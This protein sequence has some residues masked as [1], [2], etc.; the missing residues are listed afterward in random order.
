MKTR[1]REPRVRRHLV[2][3]AVVSACLLTGCSEGPVE[4]DDPSGSGVASIPDPSVTSKTSGKSAADVDDQ[5]PL[6]RLDA[7]PADKAALFNG[8]VKCLVA[9]GGPKYNQA[10]DGKQMVSSVGSETD[11][12]HVACASKRP[13]EYED[14]AKRTDPSGFKEDNLKMYRCAQAAGYKL[15]T[16]DRETGQFGITSTKP[17]GDFGSPKMMACRNEAF[18]LTS[19]GSQP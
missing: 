19:Q 16:P 15:T 14:R 7:T 9:E 10:F 11:A 12:A 2:T 13:E 5:R 3:V 4:A 17:N 18:G 1:V 8:W 6:V